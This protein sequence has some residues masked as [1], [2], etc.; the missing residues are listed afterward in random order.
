MPP[1][2][3]QARF[4][5]RWEALLAEERACTCTEISDRE[6]ARCTRQVLQEVHAFLNGDGGAI[7]SEKACDWMQFCY[8]LGLY[9]ETAALFR[10]VFQDDLPEWAYE[11]ARKVAEACRTRIGS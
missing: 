11:R 9:R 5:E 6:L 3:F 1:D 4:G 2:R 10:H 8:A 7:S